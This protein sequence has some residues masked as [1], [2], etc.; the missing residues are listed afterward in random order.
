M[1]VAVCEDNELH[2]EMFSC[3]LERYASEKS[4]QLTVTPYK[5]GLNFLY[6]VEDG[7]YFDIVFLDIYME[8]ILGIDIAHKLRAGGYRGS[9][10]FLTVSPDFALESYDVDADSY[11]LKPLSYAKLKTVLDGITYEA[12]PCTYQIC[13]RSSV[14]NL[15]FHEILYIESQNSKCI[16]HTVSGVNYTAYKTLNTIENELHSSSFFRC[17]QSFLVNL[18]HVK[19]IDKE[20]LLQNGEIVPIRQRGLKPARE[21]FVGYTAQKQA[22]LQHG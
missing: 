20:F 14:I 4:I 19:Q 17:H 11:L 9:I 10:I 18:E 6:D 21:A 8:D 15:A 1:R 12:A 7:A 13:Q 2:R 22:A 16:I 5:N 3:M